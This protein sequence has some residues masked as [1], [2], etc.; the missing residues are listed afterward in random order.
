VSVNE[1]TTTTTASVHVTVWY[2]TV[3][4]W[5]G[6]MM[7]LH[8][9]SVGVVSGYS[10]WLNWYAAAAAV[11]VVRPPVTHAPTPTRR[12]GGLLKVHAAL[13]LAVNVWLCGMTRI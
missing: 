6:C 5:L 1:F 10:G 9:V 8:G 12:R 4:V 11:C 13:T 2:L 3:C 7:A